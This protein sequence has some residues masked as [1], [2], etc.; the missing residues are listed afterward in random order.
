MSTFFSWQKENKKTVLFAAQGK[1]VWGFAEIGYDL[2]SLA[3]YAG[4]ALNAVL[5]L[6]SRLR[7]R[8]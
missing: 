6:R 5:R 2:R 7:H 1:R 4:L 8:K 3:R